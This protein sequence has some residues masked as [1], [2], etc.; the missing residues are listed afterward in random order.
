[1]DFEV[2]ELNLRLPILAAAIAGLIVAACGA[3]ASSSDPISEPGE[4]EPAPADAPNSPTLPEPES[5]I[6]PFKIVMLGDSLTAGFG[7]P[8]A[9]ALP[10]Q[11]ERRLTSETYAVEFVNAG[12]SGD[13]SAGGLARYDWSVASVDP[14][15]LVLAL[16]ANDYLSGL[17]P[18][19]TRAN[20][21]TIVERAQADGTDVFLVSLSARSSAAS[22]P[23][24]AAFAA[25]YPDLAATY[26][27]PLYEGLM[28]PVF[29]KP[30]LL[31]PDGLHPTA[32]GVGAI[33]QPL[34]D[35]LAEYLSDR[36]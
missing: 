4:V 31:M 17:D 9:D 22:A 7:L 13:T 2:A 36:D 35:T 29:D 11:L 24:A 3:P 14:D 15:I 6:D 27:V 18:A 21:S 10:E 20:L 12:V 30:E 16:G 1:M 5:A 25:I 33:A 26:G 23:R 19:Q 32:D 8:P 28:D 34:A